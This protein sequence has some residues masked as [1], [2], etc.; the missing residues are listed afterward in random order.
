MVNRSGRL[1]SGNLITVISVTILIGV[2]VFATTLAAGWAIAGLFELGGQ[3]GY[4]LM[5]VFS[6]LGAW[7][8][9]KFLQR[10][11]QVEPIRE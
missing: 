11:K 3:I 9:W 10:A 6:A 2:E 8:M 5:A 4:V 1:N 7:G